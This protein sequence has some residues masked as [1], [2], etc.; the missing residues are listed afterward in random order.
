LVEESALLFFPLII[1]VLPLLYVYAK[2]VDEGCMIVK[3]NVKDLVEG[4]WL[5]R[6]V[7]VGRKI[8]EA[9]WDGVS[10][11]D[12]KLLQ[13]LNRKVL[14]KQGIAFVPAILISFILY[15]FLWNSSWIM[16]LFSFF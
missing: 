15:L 5:Y 6:D 13:K 16:Q 12:I 3:V 2:A 9:D 1:L 8:V 11:E 7:K 14:V 4:D 10:K